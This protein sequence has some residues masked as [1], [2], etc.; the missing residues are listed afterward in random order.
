[1]KKV[2]SASEIH[3]LI[4]ERR[5]AGK[6][7]GF[8]PTM[9][10]L[11]EGHVSLLKRARELSEFVVSSI[12]INPVQ[13]GLGEDFSEYP[14]DE[15]GDC[16]ILEENGC[17]LVFLPDTSD[18]FF[19]SK[20]I[21]ISIDGL[22][23]HLC[24]S[25][26]P[27][28]FEGVLL[29]VAK[30]FNIV[31]PDMA[32]FGQKDAQQAVIIQRM[33]AELDFPVKII[34]CPTIREEDGLAMSSR[35]LY[36]SKEDRAAAAGLITGLRDAF[37]EAGNGERD[38]SVLKNLVEGR[39]KASGFEPDYVEIVRAGSLDPVEKIEGM[40]LMAAAGYLSGTRL[41]DNIAFRTTGKK[42]EEILLEFPEWSRD[43]K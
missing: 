34:L 15:E 39:M 3:R 20:K 21:G 38:P 17:D 33:T 27:G 43:G 29:I 24:G 13:F 5:K 16:R 35:N 11:H 40:V 36:L 23:D 1:M 32:F 28:H 37:A 14:R 10:G 26:R 22:T 6:T 7:I 12:F 2:K 31:T 8:V 30:L 41:I 19:D 25:S 4:F 42:V 18:L 9:G